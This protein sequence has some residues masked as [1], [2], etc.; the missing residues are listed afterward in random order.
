MET[1]RDSRLN[2]GAASILSGI[3]DT[4]IK[5]QVAALQK[6]TEKMIK[7]MVD[8]IISDPQEASEMVRK[9][10]ARRQWIIKNYG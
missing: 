2:S 7:Q 4:E 3:T 5:Q 8:D 6:V 10:I 1:L 9:L